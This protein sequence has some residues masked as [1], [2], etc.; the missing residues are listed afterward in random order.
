[1]SLHAPCKLAK[2]VTKKY[3]YKRYG[4]H[5]DDEAVFLAQG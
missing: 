3:V 1:M 2:F 4:A 5:A